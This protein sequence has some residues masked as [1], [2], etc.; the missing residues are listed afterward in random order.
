MRVVRDARQEVYGI[1]ESGLSSGEGLIERIRDPDDEEDEGGTKGTR[2]LVIETEMATVMAACSR[3]GTKLPGILRQAWGGERLSTLNRKRI[4]ASSS[5]IAIIGHIIPR[6]S[7]PSSGSPTWP[8]APGT[9]TSRCTSSAGGCSRCPGFD[10][11]RTGT[12][13]QGSSARRSTGRGA[14]GPSPSTRGAELWRGQLYGEFTE[15]DEDTAAADFVQ[16]AAPY[17]RRLAA[18]YAALDGRGK[19]TPGP[20][21][22]RRT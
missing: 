12:A 9:G 8:A 17:C 6:S 14:A 21:C 11:N 7:G 10:E 19:P 15:F 16:R 13:H 3:E 22:R 2:L 20:G 18:L 4:V 1:E 5:H